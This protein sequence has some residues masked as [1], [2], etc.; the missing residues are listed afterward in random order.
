MTKEERDIT[1]EEMTDEKMTEEEIEKHANAFLEKVSPKI[2]LLLK[3]MRNEFLQRSLDRMKKNGVPPDRLYSDRWWEY[4]PDFDETRHWLTGL[5]NTPPVDSQVVIC[6]DHPAVHEW[7]RAPGVFG[8][9]LSI[10]PESVIT[11]RDKNG[12][13][14][15]DKDGKQVRIPGIPRVE[16][17]FPEDDYQ[18]GLS[19]P[20]DCLKMREDDEDAENTEEA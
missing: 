20:A 2:D 17:A 1:E 5:Y 12:D 14:I 7:M 4:I 19:F 3:E 13:P 10:Q 15:L 16:V 11:L 9:V 8:V 6:K 18:H